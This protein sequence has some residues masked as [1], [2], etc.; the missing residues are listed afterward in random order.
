MTIQIPHSESI[1]NG[2]WTIIHT[3]DRIVM[4]RYNLVCLITLNGSSFD[5]AATD[6]SKQDKLSI[7]GLT[8]GKAK[9]THLGK[10]LIL[11][12]C[13]PTITHS[14]TS[15]N[16]L[17][18]FRSLYNVTTKLGM[19]SFSISQ[20]LL[21]GISWYSIQGILDLFTQTIVQIFACYNEII[22]LPPDHRTEI[23]TENHV[24]TFGEHREISKTYRRIHERYYWPS[25]KTDVQNLNAC[26]SCQLQ[27]LI[28]VKIRLWQ[29]LPVK[30]SI[31][32]PWT[33]SDHYQQLFPEIP[34]YSRSKIF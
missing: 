33:Y 29:T 14:I 4:R 34:T 25:L 1:Y 28:R 27:K 17:E 13:T 15:E 30:L 31:K 2:L 22:T 26:S 7:T 21:E 16:L 18:C 9:V 24:S 3:R 20:F 10:H 19:S 32:F 8:F 23:F 5:P 11:H 12:P 6:L